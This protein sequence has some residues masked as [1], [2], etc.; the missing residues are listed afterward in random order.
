VG[1]AVEVTAI[2]SE[3]TPIYLE[4]RERLRRIA[5]AA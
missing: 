5:A 4:I 1:G 3:I 2:I